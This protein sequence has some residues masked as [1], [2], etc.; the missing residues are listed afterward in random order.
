MLIVSKFRDYY[1]TAI[2]FGVDKTI[3]YERNTEKIDEKKNRWRYRHESKGT[4][5]Y[6]YTSDTLTIGFCGNIHPVVRIDK[7]NRNV[8]STDYLKHEYFFFY[9]HGSMMKFI[10][11]EG[12]SDS[13]RWGRWEPF[14]LGIEYFNPTSERHTK[15]KLDKLFIE[16]KVPVFLLSNEKLILNPVLKDYKFAKIKDPFTAFQ[17]IMQYISG[18][19][20]VGTPEMVNISNEDMRDKKG[21][22]DWSFKTHPSDTKKPRKRGR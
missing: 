9:D 19:L 18:V 5:K 17:D 7:Q 2:A 4:K 13:G 15:M 20:G 8:F 22:D 10:E 3:V 11:G 12:V 16:H 21:F 14:T 6:N 1:D